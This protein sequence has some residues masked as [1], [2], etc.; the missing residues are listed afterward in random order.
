MNDRGVVIV[1]SA[2]N[3]NSLADD[4]FF[5]CS[6]DNVIC[7]GA[8]DN[9]GINEDYL[10][11]LENQEKDYDKAHEVFNNIFKEHIENKDMATRN[12]RR[13]EYS[14]YGENVDIYAPGS[15]KFYYRDENGIDHE[16]YD[17]DTSYAAPIVAGVAA[18]FMSE[19]PYYNFDT[20]K[21]KKA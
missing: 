2:G 19:F 5:P 13:A 12:Y 8:I 14:N 21:K 20:K 6:F 18:T 17:Q 9:L 7:V 1:V 10:E 3:Y 15:V 16:V 4:V 11:M